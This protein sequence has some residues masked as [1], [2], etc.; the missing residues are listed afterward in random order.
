MI[1]LKSIIE[2]ILFIYG[3]PLA[4]EK[5]AKIVKSEEEEIKRALA[6]LKKDY[7]K[8]GLA[9]LEKD[10]S[11]QLGSNPENTQYIKELVKNEFSEELSRAAVETMAIIAYKGPLTR[12]EIEYIRGV[13]SSFIIR[14]LLMRGLVERMEN[15]KDARS[16]LYKVGFDFLKHLGVMRLEDLPRY[17][18]FKKETMGFFEEKNG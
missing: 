14:N 3:E 18:E 12:L 1:D 13:N 7:Q 4:L 8:S 10:G 15:P 6:E 5:I 11:Y 16:Y 2:S 17:Q 9:I